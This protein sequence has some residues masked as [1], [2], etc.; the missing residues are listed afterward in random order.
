MRREVNAG[1]AAVSRMI[2]KLETGDGNGT[3]MS[4]ATA[5]PADLHPGSDADR[6]SQGAVVP[7][8]A[9]TALHNSSSSTA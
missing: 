8:T 4:S 9:A 6:D 3:G 5:S 7:S 1:I 2:E